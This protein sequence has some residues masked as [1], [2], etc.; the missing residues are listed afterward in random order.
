MSE[1]GVGEGGILA[2]CLI[3]KVDRLLSFKCLTIINLLYID[4]K[5]M[6]TFI[7]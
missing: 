5:N 1:E 2:F 4:E 6:P 3:S 7:I